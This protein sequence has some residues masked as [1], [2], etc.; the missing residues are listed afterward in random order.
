VIGKSRAIGPAFMA[1]WQ[2]IWHVISH[3]KVRTM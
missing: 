1:P 2:R 3:G